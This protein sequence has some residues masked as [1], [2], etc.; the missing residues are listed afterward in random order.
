MRKVQVTESRQLGIPTL[1]EDAERTNQARRFERSTAHLP[2]TMPEGI[3]CYRA[4][5]ERYDAALL[6]G[7]AQAAKRVLTRP[8]ARRQRYAHPDQLALAF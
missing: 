5:L 1:L 4:L 6:A 7:D 2:G 3:A 8:C